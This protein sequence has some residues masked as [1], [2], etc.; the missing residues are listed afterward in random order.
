MSDAYEIGNNSTIDPYGPPSIPYYPD[1][2]SLPLK[3]ALQPDKTPSRE[4]H[5]QLPPPP[6]P[7]RLHVSLK[8]L[9][10]VAL[11]LLLVLGSVG[12]LVTYLTRSTPGKTLDAFCTALVQRNYQNAY[13]QFAPQMQHAFSEQ[14]FINTLF[15][16][17]ITRC[18]YTPVD[19]TAASVQTGLTLQHGSTGSNHDQVRLDKDAQGVWRIT[20]LSV[21]KPG[22]IPQQAVVHH[23]TLA[24]SQTLSRLTMVLAV[25]DGDAGPGLAVA[26]GERVVIFASGTLT[27][28]A[29][30]EKIGA[31][32]TS[33]CSGSS[34]PEPALNCSSL[35]YGLGALD[36]VYEAGVHADFTVQTNDVLFLGLNVPYQSQVQGSLQLTVLTIPAGTATAFWQQPDQNGFFFSSQKGSGSFSVGIYTQHFASRITSV[37]FSLLN[38]GTETPI[39]KVP[40]DGIATSVS[41]QWNMRVGDRQMGL[42]SSTTGTPISD[43]PITVGFSLQVSGGTD[44][45]AAVNNPDGTRS[46][47]VR[48]IMTQQFKNYA[49]YEAQSSEPSQP[50]HY[51]STTAFW[52]V[53]AVQCGSGEDS[54]SAVWAGISTPDTSHIAQTGTISACQAGSPI[55]YAVWEMYP[56]RPYLIS[57]PLQPG[58]QVVATVDYQQGQFLLKL[59]NVSEQWSFT[60][61]QMGSQNETLAAECIV[62]APATNTGQIVP[63]SNFG[64]VSVSCQVNGQAIGITG[65]QISVYQMRG[66]QQHASTSDLDQQGATFTVDWQSS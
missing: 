58:D 12:T 64:S 26:A 46:G 14:I 27:M 34:R 60:T 42:E 4:H 50:M 53:P 20:D 61:T 24:A 54:G 47:A 15:L 63:L 23:L 41:C 13:Q 33:S 56:V 31:D 48:S 55:Y 40:Y 2:A 28:T 32:G 22:H 21:E 25:N 35:I 29:G 49:G 16:G 6:E 10:I 36:Q 52:R 51:D 30:G 9:F 43:G 7:R 39:C 44:A 17:E 3:S 5:E 45:P 59:E 18:T 8:H 37:L 57:Q 65:P 38:R 11:I 1:A 62:E 19:E 66:P